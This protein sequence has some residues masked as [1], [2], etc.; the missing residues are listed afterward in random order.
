MEDVSMVVSPCDPFIAL[1]VL[2]ALL[3]Y[4]LATAAVHVQLLK[5]RLLAL[6]TQFCSTP[7]ATV[8]WPSQ[9]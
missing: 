4:G 7:A 8:V 6:L 3:K 9:K 5:A 2:P 1:S